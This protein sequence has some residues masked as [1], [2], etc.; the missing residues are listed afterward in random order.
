MSLD[1]SLLPDGGLHWLIGDGAHAGIVLSSRIRLARN[2]AGFAFPI[3]AREG[4]RL[5]VL[6]QVRATAARLPSLEGAAFVRVDEC[7]PLERQVLYERHLVSRELVGLDRGVEGPAGAGVLVTGDAGVMVNEEDHLRV[8]VFRSGF[9][10]PGALAQAAM[11]SSSTMV[12]V[13]AVPPFVPARTPSRSSNA[14]STSY[15][16]RSMQE[17]LGQTRR[18]F[19]PAGSRR[20]IV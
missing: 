16:P 13:P 11:H 20:Y 14:A 3:R 8:Q 15:A 9:D 4:E 19:C 18:M 10:I 17:M 6:H 1:L 5:R 7:S 12:N 2:L